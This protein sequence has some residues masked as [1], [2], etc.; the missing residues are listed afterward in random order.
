MFLKKKPLTKPHVH[1]NIIIIKLTIYIRVKGN[2]E[3]LSITNYQ[4]WY[5]E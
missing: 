1:V 5:Y 4:A 3:I 2:L